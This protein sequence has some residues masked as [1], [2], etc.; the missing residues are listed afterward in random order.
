MFSDSLRALASVWRKCNW[1]KSK[2]HFQN[3]IIQVNH[4][5][6]LSNILIIFNED[7]FTSRYQTVWTLTTASYF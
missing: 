1:A 7:E 2:I 3:G 4:V 6:V 5:I